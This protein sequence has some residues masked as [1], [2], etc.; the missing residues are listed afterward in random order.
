MLETNVV[1]YN[2]K[3]AVPATIHQLH[4]RGWSNFRFKAL[5]VFVPPILIA[6]QAIEQLQTSSQ[7]KFNRILNEKE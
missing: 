7:A 1:K 4:G 5:K 3:T 2:I 6:T